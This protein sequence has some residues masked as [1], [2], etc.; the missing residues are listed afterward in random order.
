ME[1]YESTDDAQIDGHMDA[2]SSR[3]SGTVLAIHVEDNQTVAQ[4]QVLI[5]L[6][7]TNYQI[8]VDQARSNL[9]QAESQLA[10]ANP[11]IPITE[12]SNQSAAVTSQADVDSAEAQVAAAQRDYDSALADLRQAEALSIRASSDEARYQQLVAKDEVSK[13]LYDQKVADARASEAAVQARNAAAQA[14]QRKI[15]ESQAALQ[16]AK[17]RL[18]ETQSNNPRRI[19][20]NRATV[21]TRSASVKTA[22]AQLDQA[23]LNLS[24]CKIVAPSAGVVGNKT[25]EIG[26][27]IEAGQ[28]LFMITQ[29]NDI[30]VTA[31]YKETQLQQMQAGQPVTVSVDAI[32][33]DFD[34]YIESMPGA[35]GAKYSL[36]PPENATGNY[37]K[38]VQRLP[39]RIRLK[40][41]QNGMDRLRPGMSVETST[42]IR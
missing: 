23:L 13:E 5:E 38:V 11:A 40:A 42:K 22:K 16:S 29:T 27:H 3:V 17:S 4:D 30:W 24:Y 15:A 7:P 31:D 35:T 8:A 41:G 21:A 2:I 12:T 34:G 28:P 1:S 6:D 33:L 14:A 36:L 10:A 18:A 26:Q 39:V 19:L 37:V 32:G 9:A 25:V 20:I